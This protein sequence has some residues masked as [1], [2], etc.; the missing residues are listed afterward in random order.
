MQT[1][2]AP[3]S[4]VGFGPSYIEPL[5][6][7]VPSAGDLGSFTPEY[8]QALQ[9]IEDMKLRYP[10]AGGFLS[11]LQCAAGGPTIGGLFFDLSL[12][13]AGR[14]LIKAT[15]AGA[16]DLFSPDIA[17]RT[18]NYQLNDE[19]L[20]IPL[21]LLATG[22]HIA[23]HKRLSTL[24]TEQFCVWLAD[25]ATFSF[26]ADTRQWAAA[27][28]A[29]ISPLRISLLTWNIWGLPFALGFGSKA[30]WRYAAIAEKLKSSTYDVVALQE[31]WDRKTDVILHQAGFPYAAKGRK[32]HGLRDSSGLLTL[33]RYPIIAAETLAFS[34][35]SG[36]ERFVNKGALFTRV[37][38]PTGQHLDI[39]NVHLA[40]APEGLNHLF[41]SGAAA[42]HIRAAQIE[43][44]DGWIN[45]RR[46]ANI[47]V[48]LIG[49]FN[50][51][52]ESHEY[53]LLKQRF[54]N[55]LYRAR[56]PRLSMCN[57]RTFLGCTFDTIKNRWALGKG[58]G[59]RLDQ[60]WLP[61]VNPHELTVQSMVNRPE[62]GCELSDH[63]GLAATITFF[64]KCRNQIPIIHYNQT[65]Y[66]E[67]ENALLSAS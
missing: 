35:K 20:H 18:L 48:I 46:V 9:F 42:A 66:N 43:Q 34:R 50:T 13:P 67:E 26:H 30:P 60:I 28:K 11:C 39:Y 53:L 3:S 36:I 37:A 31:M 15:L 56:Y 32:M 44:L 22:P 51:I 23:M 58:A 57:E 14:R 41:T 52:E 4:P 38:L 21:K 24:T 61:F 49:D 62:T 40:S 5:S 8:R 17:Q 7:V 1:A 25:T 65:A 19:R 33:S 16:G 45:S 47:P 2:V 10:E 12:N 29:R 63:Y 27:M 55:D 64:G 54:S 59:G 6:L